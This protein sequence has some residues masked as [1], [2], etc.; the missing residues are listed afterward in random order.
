MGFYSG[1][2][3]PFENLVTERGARDVERWEADSSPGSIHVRSE[4]VDKTKLA[5]LRPLCCLAESYRV[6]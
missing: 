6:M 4:H 2:L 3:L 1:E 5:P